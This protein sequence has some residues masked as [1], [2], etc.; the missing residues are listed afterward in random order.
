VKG[1]IT[2][3]G[4]STINSSGNPSQM[5]I[6]GNT[7]L[8]DAAGNLTGGTKYGCVA[9]ASCPTE[10][11]KINGTP[12]ISALI[13]APDGVGSVSGGSGGCDAD[14]YPVNGFVGALWFKQWDSSS[15][16]SGAV[17]CAKGDYGSFLAT[18]NSAPPSTSSITGWQRQEIP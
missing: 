1:K 14:S 8:R 17:V 6:Y 9:G 7:F 16:P 11:V 2:L 13:H 10:I 12:T 4:S 3:G 18:Q 5:Q 15:S